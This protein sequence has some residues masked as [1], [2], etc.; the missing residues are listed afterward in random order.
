M[1]W[2]LDPEHLAR[3]IEVHN[4][5]EHDYGYSHHLSGI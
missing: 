1:N 5:L 2:S 3:A 4:I